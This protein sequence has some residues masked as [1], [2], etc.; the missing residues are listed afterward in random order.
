M[1]KIGEYNELRV[2]RDSDYGLYLADTDNNE[3]LLPR[4]YVTPDMQAGETLRVFVY[5]DSEDRPVATTETPYARVGEFAYL[6]VSDVNA[7]GAF[8]DWGL[9]GKQLLVPFSEQ[10]TRMV[11]GGIY[12]VYVY[13]DHTTGRVVGSAKT[14]R[15]LGNVIPRY[16]R[17]AEVEALVTEHTPLGYKVIVDNLHRGMIYENEI[18]APLEVEQTVKAY[19]K[20]VRPDGKI[21]LSVGAGAMDRVGEIAPRIAAALQVAGDGRLELS[22]HSSPEIIKELFQCSKKD[23]KRA[24]GTLYRQ[25]VI[26]INPDSIELVK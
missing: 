23:F 2:A 14:D 26:K 7:T 1:M 5:R 10:R 17:G 12:L 6:Q 8:M 25:G 15:F 13:L 21:D 11:R 20:H 18:Y 4:R 24:L 19:V 3:V 16:G 9:E 22:D